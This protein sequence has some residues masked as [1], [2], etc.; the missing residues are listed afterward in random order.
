MKHLKTIAL[1]LSIV[2]STHLKAEVIN[3]AFSPDFG[4]GYPD[5]ETVGQKDGWTYLSL[6]MLTAAE[7]IYYGSAAAY[8]QTS[9]WQSNN[10]FLMTPEKANGVGW[11]TF[12]Y[13]TSEASS[14]NT[15][16]CELEVKISEDGETFTVID[17]VKTPIQED[18]TWFRYS[19]PINNAAAK[20]V[21]LEI[22]KNT[23]F[24]ANMAIDE[25]GI[26][27]A[28]GPSLIVTLLTPI[29]GEVGQTTNNPNALFVMGS[30]LS[31]DITLSLDQGENSPFSL[32]QNVVSPT[33]GVATAQI[34]VDFTPAVKS[35]S[36][37]FIK[38]SGNNL[39]DL[40]YK[41]TGLGLERTVVEGFN[42]ASNSHS[43]GNSDSFDYLGWSIV[44]GSFVL[45]SSYDSEYIYEGEGAIRFSISL[46][47]PKKVGGIGSFS[48][49]YRA[50][51]I[52]ENINFIV[53]SS[54]DGTEW[55]VI[56]RLTASSPYFTQY[57][58]QLNN[59]DSYIKVE[60]ETPSTD[61][62]SP[63]LLIDAFSITE[64]DAPLP[65]A[66]GNE[67]RFLK[68]TELAVD[69]PYPFAVPVVFAN[70]TGDVAA[71][72]DNAQLQ[73]GEISA[74][75]ITINYQPEEG[76]TFAAGLLSI[77]GGGLNFPVKIPVAAYLVSETLFTDFDGDNWQGSSSLYYRTN[78]GWMIIN[79]Q[80]NTYNAGFSSAAAAS[81]AAKGS[82]ISPPKSG[83]IG[84]IQ[85]Y[86]KGAS[87]SSS[88]NFSVYVSEDGINWGEAIA[89]VTGV[90]ADAYQEYNY[91]VG[92]ANAKYVKVAVSGYECY[93]ENF[94]VTKNGVGISKLSF[95]NE[96]AFLTPQGQAQTLP[97]N[98]EGSNITSDLTVSF[99]QGT[100]FSS[101][102]STIAAADINGKTYA[103][104]VTFQSE[105]GVY[106]LDTLVVSGDCLAFDYTFPLKGYV[107]QDRLFESFDDP[108]TELS[109]GNY[110]TANGWA[111]SGGSRNTYETGFGSAAAASLSSYS[112]GQMVS[113][114]KSGG[115]GSLQFYAKIG[116]YDSGSNITVSTSENGT[117]W[118][119]LEDVVSVTA[120][121]YTE[122]VVPIDRP[123]AKYI[124]IA[125]SGS[126]CDFENITVTKNGVGISKVSL[127]N[128]PFFKTNKGVLQTENLELSGENITSDLTVSF[129]Q[130][131]AFSS[132][133][134]TIAAA[135]ING[136]TYEL[137]VDFQSETGSYLLDTLIVSGSDLAYDYLF[138][139]KGY[140][141]QDLIH[142]NF[143]GDW[144][145]GAS[146]DLFNVDGWEVT[147]GSRDSYSNIY[148]GSASLGLSVSS[149]AANPASVFSV[150]KSGGV[151]IISFYYKTGYDAVSL[152]VLTYKTLADTPVEVETINI[153]AETPYTEYRK[154]VSD[155]DAQY[156]EI[157][158]LVNPDKYLNV[159]IDAITVTANGKGIPTATVPEIALFSAY[160]EETD[161]RTFDLQFENV[162]EEI[163]LS[164]ANGADF[165]INKT[166]ITPVEGAATETVSITYTPA[167]FFSGDVLLIESAGLLAPISIPIYGN[168]L[169]DKLFQ[170]FNAPDWL[171][172]E[173][174]GVLDGWIITQG[175]R[176]RQDE[177]IEGDPN[178]GGSL[179]IAANGSNSGN[180]ISP[181]KSGGIHT[182]EFYYRSQLYYTSYLTLLTET[183][184]DGQT[185]TQIDSQDLAVSEFQPVRHLYS[186]EIN[187]R[188]AKYFRIQVQLPAGSSQST[189]GYL[190]VDS[191]AIDALP[192]LYLTEDVLEVETSTVPVTIPVKLR[193]VLN[194][195]A[196]IVLA[197]GTN[198]SL[199]KASLTPEELADEA[200]V[201]F[202]VNFTAEE[203]G[204]YRDTVIISNT[205][206]E[207]V[208]IPLSVLFDGTGISPVYDNVS[209]YLSK[210][211]A[212]NVLGASAGTKVTVI[213][214]QGQSL[215][216]AQMNSTQEHFDVPLQTGV[217]LVKVGDRV[218]KV[219][220]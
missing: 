25:I 13:R 170:D 58:K 124:K 134:T 40:A 166:T 94:T 208:R 165:S 47:S 137:P 196:S 186:N 77:S 46:T 132:T 48:F 188:N 127:E 74:N 82:L 98:L 80:R 195:D 219:K 95:L 2:L 149:Y 129:K 150:P 63:L 182:V 212:L 154:T 20:Y 109:Y 191:I 160:S 172:N 180:V 33:A 31:S 162:E 37:D 147:S 79:G 44:N 190:F 88:S 99:K 193:G 53:S 85:F 210:E 174:N 14:W 111:I 119:P 133:V 35:T 164:L 55:T 69:A 72:M 5:N 71:S 6:G 49:F 91:T 138:P 116:S 158:L 171:P 184:A 139:L 23:V 161:T 12:L 41:I 187:D 146:Y 177:M 9:S 131:T 3:Q 81:V 163:R 84:D 176:T 204:T 141:L 211:G 120:S 148:E 7:K 179:R 173:G 8:V 15:G 57:I 52:Y 194:T 185:W 93:F 189:S 126:S 201:S 215:F 32:S 122:C 207:E 43:Y 36:S 125:I 153:P 205:D 203:S 110:I 62:S 151:G 197:A 61:Y 50:E 11:L 18:K 75:S 114:P 155:A 64:K 135:D 28:P 104:P 83:G 213:N 209:V 21:K 102:V 10:G 59:D 121:S 78:D 66:S 159:Y 118:T 216:N 214:V 76:K 115:I 156:V 39:P 112:N 70:L 199:D 175:R 56:D 178:T 123:D 103:L 198:Y 92:N 140:V 19:K 220:K 22:L 45:G 89:S 183:S 152:R 107:L 168:I 87:S 218:W 4:P 105:T 145:Q 181:A 117:D 38:V 200:I 143:N 142:Q 60:F 96:P 108:W 54:S 30:S 100:A 29:E 97:L 67:V 73:V 157:Q 128:Q 106:F 68:G 34:S 51:K 136:E 24:T 65:S 42:P 206:I 202:N 86:A 169:K 113:P 16:D 90:P 1:F 167:E 27:D 130:G 26:T 217:Y 192:Y 144:I 17:I 101:T